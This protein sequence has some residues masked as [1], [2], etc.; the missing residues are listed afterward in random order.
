VV[1]VV[2]V[3]VAVEPNAQKIADFLA[4]AKA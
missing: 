3:V 4:A 2:V 1:E